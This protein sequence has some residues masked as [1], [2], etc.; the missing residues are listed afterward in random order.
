VNFP[1]RKE[2]S[3]PGGAHPRRTNVLR[4]RIPIRLVH[5]NR[6]VYLLALVD[7]GADDCLFPSEVAQELNLSLDRRNVNR[8]GGIGAGH[9]TAAF[10]N[11]RIEI[12]NDVTFP[13]YAGFSDA[14][15]VVPILG[16]AG[17]FDRFEVRFN[18]PNEV[19]EL[20]F[21]ERQ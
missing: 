18:Q 15:S 3:T 17:F 2:P 7:S 14:P 8:Y 16:Q 20:R 9:I 4:P 21:I 10:M 6:F 5:K 1:H 13:L 12:D 11:V 19:I